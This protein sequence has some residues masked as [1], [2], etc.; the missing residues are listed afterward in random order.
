MTGTVTLRHPY[1]AQL[2]LSLTWWEVGTGGAQAV[3][4]HVRHQIFEKV[5]KT[6]CQSARDKIP[7]PTLGESNYGIVRP[8]T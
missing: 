5:T 2:F 3:K 8:D 6:G 4:I 1:L 7:L